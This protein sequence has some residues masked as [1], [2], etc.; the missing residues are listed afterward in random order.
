MRP[1]SGPPK[2]KKPK[3]P[4]NLLARATGIKQKKNVNV[5]VKKFPLSEFA[6]MLFHYD[7][8]VNGWKDL[9]WS[10]SVIHA[11]AINQTKWYQLFTARQDV[12]PCFKKRTYSRDQIDE[13]RVEWAE[14]IQ[15]EI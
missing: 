2:N 15:R 3:S 9:E 8:N 11:S 12:L 7:G 13:M 4:T 10:N 6:I 14:C 1:L 5:I